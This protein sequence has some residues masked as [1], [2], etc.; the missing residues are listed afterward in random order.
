MK[1]NSRKIN[2]GA[3]ISALRA[4][5]PH[6]IPIMAGFLVLGS[7]YGIMMV[8]RG[9]PF[10]YPILTSILIFAGSMEFALGGILLGA[11]NPIEAFMMAL[12]I[13]ARHIFYGISM[14]GK[15]R[16]TGLKKIYLIFALCDETFS[17][18]CTAEPPVGVDR[19]LFML[20]TSLLNQLYW[21]VGASVGG[22][23]GSLLPIVPRGFDFAMTALFVCILLEALLK[24]G[25]NIPAVAVGISASV[26]SLL[27]FGKDAF[28]IPAMGLMLLALGAIK[29]PMEKYRFDDGGDGK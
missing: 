5:F 14:V 6:T 16:G 23:F 25:S 7:S 8:G 4:A 15:Y 26:L 24:G 2:T 27:I 29:R 10:F 13:N 9:F 19:G 20:Y 17:V 11:F 18:N 21:V 1:E 3:H 22:I 12:M 28:L